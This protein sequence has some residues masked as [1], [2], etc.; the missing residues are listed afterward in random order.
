MSR[1]KVFGGSCPRRAVCVPSAPVTGAK[2][3][4]DRLATDSSGRG[5]RPRARD[6]RDAALEPES[7]KRH[8]G[9]G[10]QRAKGEPNRPPPLFAV[11]VWAKGARAPGDCSRLRRPKAHPAGAVQQ[12]AGPSV[13]GP[14]SSFGNQCLCILQPFPPSH[15]ESEP[16]Q[17]Q[18]AVTTHLL[19]R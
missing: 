5:R 4:R 12:P 19:R 7:E 13:P 9:E 15:W 16:A 1:G 3:Q 11:A 8:A 17:G 10:R 14:G 6:A 2:V 18:R